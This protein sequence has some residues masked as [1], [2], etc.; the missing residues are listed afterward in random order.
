MLDCAHMPKLTHENRIEEVTELFV[1]SMSKLNAK[2]AEWNAEGFHIISTIQ[3][4]DTGIYRHYLV[5]E[6][7]HDG[8]RASTFLRE[9]VLHDV[10]LPVE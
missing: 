3:R 8:E 2:L 1:N 9:E 6:R 7:S 5:L 4:M 10:S